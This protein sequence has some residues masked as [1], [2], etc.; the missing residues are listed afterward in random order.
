MCKY[1][2]S[3]H[4]STFKISSI[5]IHEADSFHITH[6]AFTGRGNKIYVFYSGL[7]RTLVAMTT[8]SFYR[9]IMGKVK[10]D[11]FC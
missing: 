7:I 2:A 9:L 3:V 5:K 11:N 10:I 8:Y 1:P 4:P 6:I